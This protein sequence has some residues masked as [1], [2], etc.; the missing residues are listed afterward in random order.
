MNS[1]NNIFISL[2][3]RMIW[4]SIIGYGF[5]HVELYLIYCFRCA[6]LMGFFIVSTYI[7]L[8]LV[9]WIPHCCF[10]VVLH[11]LITHCSIFVSF[12]D[13][14]DSYSSSI[15]Y[16]QNCCHLMKSKTEYG[17][18]RAKKSVVI[19]SLEVFSLVILTSCFEISLT[20][21][22]SRYF[23]TRCLYNILYSGP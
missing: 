10:L 2:L 3:F 17:K 9:V 20:T 16:F 13:F 23:V 22:F 14:I 4:Q 5:N 1:S 8:P 12:T 6:L 19:A 18:N 7:C 21:F 11:V 15:H